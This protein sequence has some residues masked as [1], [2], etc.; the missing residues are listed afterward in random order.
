MPTR[1]S[2][3]AHG[4][5]EDTGIQERQTEADNAVKVSRRSSVLKSL[6]G[7]WK[8]PHDQP[9]QLTR[10]VSHDLQQVC[11]SD[12]CLKGR[13]PGPV[14]NSH[15]S[16]RAIPSL[17][18]T[19][20]FHR[21]QSERR[22]KLLEVPQTEHEKRAASAERKR[23]RSS[24]GP[25]RLRPT[26]PVPLPS[27][28]AP[29]VVRSDDDL[30]FTPSN[31]QGGKRDDARQTPSDGML[32]DIQRQSEKD[33]AIDE[34]GDKHEDDGDDDDE[35]IDEAA[36]RDEYERRWILNLSMHF[37][38]K[39]NREKFFVTY[40]EEINKWRRLTISLD[41]RNSPPGSLEEELCRL[42]H[43]RDKSFRIFDSI[44]ESLSDVQ[45]YDTVTNL[46]L[47]TT[48]EDGQ[49]HVHVREDANETIAHPAVA[50]MSHVQCPL[51]PESALSFDSHISGFVY[52]VRL[53]DRVLIKKEIPGPDTVD[54]FLYEVN[55]LDSLVGC[56]NI[57]QLQGLITDDA[58]SVVKGLLITYAPHGALVDMLY[59]FAGELPF[60]R[61]EKWGKQIVQGLSDIHEAGFVQGD[62][63]LSNIVIDEHDDALIIDINRRGCPVGW[64]PPELGR[65]IDSGQRISMHIGVKTDLYQLGMVLWA[66]AE[67]VDEPERSRPLP[68]LHDAVPSHYSDVVATCLS[69][70]PRDRV[71][72]TRLLRMFP[73]DAGRCMEGGRTLVD[74]HIPFQPGGKSPSDRTMTSNRSNKEYIDPALA[75][76]IDEIHARQRDRA[77]TGTSNFPSDQVTYVDPTESG[78]GSINYHFESSGSWIVGRSRGRSPGVGGHRRRSS[79]YGGATSATSLSASPAQHKRHRATSDVSE[80]QSP[81]PREIDAVDLVMPDVCVGSNGPPLLDRTHFSA[82]ARFPPPE[83]QDSGFDEQMLESMRLEDTIVPRPSPVGQDPRIELDSPVVCEQ[84][85]DALSKEMKEPAPAAVQSKVDAWTA[86]GMD[87]EED[88]HNATRPD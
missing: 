24:S 31:D 16:R 67:Q 85:G 3:S 81:Y 66:L 9:D 12:D 58:G 36:I 78:Q 43:Q 60:H 28:S 42:H 76:T 86:A 75:V 15:A 10:P 2:F 40:A 33:L 71:S 39:S 84:D 23:G 27:V 20:T 11:F 79:P 45:F 14:D 30:S 21:Q 26:R 5:L 37:R 63:T 38:D 74:F 70:N 53:H 4:Q 52:K 87:A 69:D 1:F 59:D 25:R 88:A 54:E 41:Y 19:Q 57:V 62:L 77:N 8:R 6:S 34:D 49:L 82:V 51:Y 17:P 72:A 7:I 44:R 35:E 47:E 13:Q 56:P 80:P 32:G 61:R 83:H 18:R 29:D 65:L 64:E 50:L 46:K 73:P 48:P 22:D 68:K 55:A